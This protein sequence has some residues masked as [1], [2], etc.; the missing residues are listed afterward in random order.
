M[1]LQIITKDWLTTTHCSV[2]SYM[3]QERN[4]KH[5]WTYFTIFCSKKVVKVF[6]HRKKNPFLTFVVGF[7]L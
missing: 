1:T 6:K 4:E 3:K 7:S 2:N 5:L